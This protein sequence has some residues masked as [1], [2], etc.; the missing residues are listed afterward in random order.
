LLGINTFSLNLMH[1]WM[2]HGDWEGFCAHRQGLDGPRLW[3]G[4]G[5]H[6]ASGS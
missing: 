3:L 4:T 5:L 1:R 2:Y 6:G